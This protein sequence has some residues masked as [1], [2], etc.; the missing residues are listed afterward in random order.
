MIVLLSG[1]MDTND[2]AGKLQPLLLRH[3]H[4]VWLAFKGKLSREDD[5]AEWERLRCELRLPPAR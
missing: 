1:E 3:A 4:L 5:L 2:T